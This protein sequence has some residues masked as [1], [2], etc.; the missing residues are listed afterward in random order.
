VPS[1]DGK[2][3]LV[4]ENDNGGGCGP[5]FIDDREWPTPIDQPHPIAPGVHEI[6]CGGA[7]EFEIPQGHTFY[8]D[9]WGP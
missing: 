8:F 9:Y 4:I 1:P 3:Y 7:I 6:R 5:M 2:T